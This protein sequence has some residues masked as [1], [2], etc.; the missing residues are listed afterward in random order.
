MCYNKMQENELANIMVNYINRIEHLMK[1][2]ADYLNGNDYISEDAIKVE[3]TELKNELCAD[4]KEVS[5]VRNYR[6]SEVYMGAFCP[7]IKEAAAYGFTVSTNSRI[8]QRMYT[9]VAE[10]QYRVSKYLSLKKGAN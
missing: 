6:G 5:L 4:A 8:D 1:I 9:A 10:V 3:Y 2:I 7:S